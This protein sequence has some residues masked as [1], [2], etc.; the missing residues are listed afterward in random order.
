MNTLLSSA[1]I[2]SDFL[3][4]KNIIKTKNRLYLYFA[5]RRGGEF[6]KIFICQKNMAPDGA[7]GKLLNCLCCTEQIPSYIR[8][9]GG[10]RCFS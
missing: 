8:G 5:A 6:L 9:S 4:R 2:N 10:G 1:V 3:K 7:W